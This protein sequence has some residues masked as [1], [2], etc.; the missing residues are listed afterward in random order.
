[1]KRYPSNDR[2]IPFA[3]EGDSGSV[4]VDTDSRNVIGMIVGYIEKDSAEFVII[5]PLPDLFLSMYDVLE[6]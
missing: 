3:S 5:R 6:N 1:M 2:S 4:A